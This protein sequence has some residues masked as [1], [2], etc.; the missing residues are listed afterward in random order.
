METFEV[1]L[2]SNACEDIYPDNT[3]SDF[4]TRFDNAIEFDGEWE[5]GVQSIFYSTHIDESV[6]KERLD[7]DVT[8]VKKTFA[9]ETNEY[10]F[11][12]TEEGKWKGFLGV[13]PT[14][15][16]EDPKNIKGVV[17]TLNKMNK[18][19]MKDK[20]A[21]YFSKN[22]YNSEPPKHFI[23]QITPR[24]AQVLGY[25]YHVVFAKKMY[26]SRRNRQKPGKG[27]LTANDYLLKYFF[28]DALQRKARIV[29]K[30][31]NDPF[32]GEQGQF[33]LLW[34]EKV[35]KRF[36]ELRAKFKRKRLIIDTYSS[37]LAVLFSPALARAIDH[38]PLIMGRGTTWGGGNTNL[39]KQSLSEA[40]YVDVYC[41]EL[42][43]NEPEVIPPL[44]LDV[45]P[46]QEESI[47]KVMETVNEQMKTSL[48][49]NFKS[50]DSDD[51]RFHLSL[52]ENGYSKLALGAGLKI[53]MSQD[54][55]Y[56]LGMPQAL[57]QAPE[58]NGV[59]PIGKT[60]SRDRHLFL[61]S[62]VAKPTA[63]G[64]QDF[65]ILQSFLHK[66]KKGVLYEKR[67]EPIVYLPVKSNYI[68][69]IQL[70]LTD[71]SYKPVSIKDSKTV[72]CLYFRKVRD[73]TMM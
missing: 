9:N 27:K 7:C 20:N 37:D 61:L 46:W 49:D 59:R 72:V 5:V 25:G 43:L 62:N 53:K 12:L 40:W 4:R 66:A 51:H 34:Y 64:Q 70:Q 44:T 26:H 45:F 31:E 35:E 60:V 41:T 15:F 23:L 13:T 19:L 32:G 17:D 36:N 58:I 29:L 11:L 56:L 6:R 24:L 10:K 47:E 55:L 16:E 50:Y 14:E 63:F 33:L 38:D 1:F 8:T 28:A 54:L 48:Q 73:K 22:G 57:L 21:F 3:P 30:A 69:M 2:P 39:K 65:P 68:D 42:R 52:D 71:D 18:L 67:F